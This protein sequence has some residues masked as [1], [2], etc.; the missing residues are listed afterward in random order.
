MG[1]TGRWR[2]EEREFV[3]ESGRFE[4][5]RRVPGQFR[6]SLTDI[7]QNLN[8]AATA[9]KEVALFLNEKK[10]EAEALARTLEV[11]KLITGNPEV[12]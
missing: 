4:G 7:M 11:R 8:K 10:A 9:V 1:E 2:G 6:C 12:R 3:G 5:R